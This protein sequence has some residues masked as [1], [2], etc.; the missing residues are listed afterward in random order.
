MKSSSRL[1]DVLHV[2]LHLAQA[3]GPVTSEVLAAA[4]STNPVVLRRLMVGLREAGFIASEKGHGGG[5][6]MAAPL[7]SVTLHDVHMALGAP[8]LVALG[9]REDRPECLVAQVVNDSLRTAIQEAEASLLSR[10]ESITL[11]QLS[12]SFDSRLRAHRP[13]KGS[14][15]HRLEH[16]HGQH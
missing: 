4:M 14:A 16:H 7:E 2:L 3:D 5:W 11:A 1:S 13:S 9:F 6:V 12:K 8:A 10:L 15:I